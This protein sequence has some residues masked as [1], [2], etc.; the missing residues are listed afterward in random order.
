MIMGSIKDK[1]KTE[2]KELKRLIEEGSIP[3]IELQLGKILLA[4][5][6][7][8]VRVGKKI[9]MFY[10][11]SPGII[12]DVL[13][14]WVRGLQSLNRGDIKFQ[15]VGSLKSATVGAIAI[16]TKGD[17][18]IY[19]RLNI[20]DKLCTMVVNNV[21]FC[22]GYYPYVTP[23]S[24]EAMLLSMFNANV[25]PFDVKIATIRYKLCK[26]VVEMLNSIEW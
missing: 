15:G 25:S 8:D 5:V 23:A 6:E 10:M 17:V 12:S 7:V 9:H 1:L 4:F 18:F 19:G 2:L 14:Q 20:D 22:N 24:I 26:G 16:S 21:A 13:C 3:A 11:G